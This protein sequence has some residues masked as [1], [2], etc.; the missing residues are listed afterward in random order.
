MYVP[1]PLIPLQDDRDAFYVC[2]L[3]DVLKKHMRWV[4]VLPQ[5]TPFYAVKCNDSVAVLKTLASL[6]TG[7][8]CA[9]KVCVITSCQGL[10]IK[11]FWQLI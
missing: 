4:R 5:I 9:S 6:G 11:M 10:L 3:G 2:D 8:D 1:F 7:F